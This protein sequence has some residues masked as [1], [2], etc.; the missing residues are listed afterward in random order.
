MIEMNNHETNL[1]IIQ[2]TFIMV[3]VSS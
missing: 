3:V 2:L 1:G